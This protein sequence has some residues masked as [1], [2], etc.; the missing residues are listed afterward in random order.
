[1]EISPDVTLLLGL[2]GVAV[3]RVDRNDDGHRVVHV[4]IDDE[5]ARA[6]PACGVFATRVKERVLTSPRDLYAGGEPISL[7][8]HE[9]R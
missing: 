3:V 4:I 1:M 5:A 8:W 2:G 9:R 6:C 7:L